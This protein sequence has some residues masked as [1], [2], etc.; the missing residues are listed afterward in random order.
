MSSKRIA[1]RYA[2]PLLEL[3]EEQSILDKVAS[4]IKGF[5]SLYE[6]NRDFKLMLASPII[7]HLRKAEI[8]KQLFDGKVEALTM[9]FF[10]IIAKK[11][12][13]DILGEI[14]E[15]FVRIYNEH[16]GLQEATVTTAFGLDKTLKASF[17]KLVKDISGKE[18]LLKEKVDPSL[19]GG[20]TLQ[21]GDRKLDE[22]VSGQLRSLKL[23]FSKEKN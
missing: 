20:Y 21:M 6:G 19:I 15:E 12:R 10:E 2:S 4:D 17:E 11:N 3:A 18:P 16:K 7:P 9:R 5:L 22:S 13:E 1:V 8:L 14:A 23:K